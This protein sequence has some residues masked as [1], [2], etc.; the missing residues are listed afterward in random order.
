MIYSFRL[1]WLLKI[2]SQLQLLLLGIKSVKYTHLY[3]P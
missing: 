3:Y 1:A 2:I